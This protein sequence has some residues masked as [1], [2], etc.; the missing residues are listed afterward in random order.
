MLDTLSR[1]EL[2]YEPVTYICELLL[3]RA[4]GSRR[5]KVC[6]PVSIRPP[7][8]PVHLHINRWRASVMA[9]RRVGG[10]WANLRHTFKINRLPCTLPT[11]ITGALSHGL[12]RRAGGRWAWFITGSTMQGTLMNHWAYIE[13]SNTLVLKPSAERPGYEIDL[14]RCQ[15]SAQVLDWIAQVASKTWAS[16]EIVG[17]LVLSLNR[18]LRFQNNYCSF[19][20]DQGIKTIPE[21][22]KIIRRQMETARW[23]WKTV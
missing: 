10:W 12:R 20:Q 1:C 19:G 14:D 3:K 4:S 7:C 6:R 17:S 9:T 15:N 16:F 11:E 21:I 5:A 23:D 22:K 2:A 8:G 18:L 13:T